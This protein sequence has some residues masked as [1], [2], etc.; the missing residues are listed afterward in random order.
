M[1]SEK[2]TN[3]LLEL[4]SWQI[5]DAEEEENKEYLDELLEIKMNLEIIKEINQK[6]NDI[7]KL[8]TENEILRRVLKEI[9]TF[10]EKI[11]DVGKGLEQQ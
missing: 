9:G 7:E 10:A 8:K 1:L 3:L 2:Q 4:L 11:I 5:E 6:E